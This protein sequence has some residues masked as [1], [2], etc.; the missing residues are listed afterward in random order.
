MHIIEQLPYQADKSSY[1]MFFI[2]KSVQKEFVIFTAITYVEV[3]WEEFE[4]KLQTVRPVTLLKRDSYIYICFPVNIAKFLI[5]P[6]LKDICVQLLLKIKDLEKPLVT[7]IITS[8]LKIKILLVPVNLSSWL[9]S[10]QSSYLLRQSQDY[11]FDL[12]CYLALLKAYLH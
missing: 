2:R 8:V 4:I 10:R 3:S 7:M 11:C 1:W 6:V 9:W 12:A 5:A